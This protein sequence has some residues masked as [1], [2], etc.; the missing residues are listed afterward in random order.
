MRINLD[1]IIEVSN[2]NVVVG[3]RAS[4]LAWEP[5]GRHLSTRKVPYASK[6]H[7]AGVVCYGRRCFVEGI[8]YQR[9][10]ESNH[11]KRIRAQQAANAL[12][13]PSPF[14]APVSGHMQ[15]DCEVSVCMYVLPKGRTGRSCLGSQEAR[16]H[17]GFVNVNA[18]DEIISAY[19]RNLVLT[20]PQSGGLWSNQYI[21]ENQLGIQ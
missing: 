3:D 19:W 18:F 12:R 13:T 5:N 7:T 15:H 2:T 16:W 1:T 10:Y 21:N 9:K 8:I 20:S 14:A 17:L 4:R 11:L 6:E